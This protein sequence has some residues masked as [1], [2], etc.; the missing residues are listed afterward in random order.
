MNC[1]TPR[2]VI[3]ATLFIGPAQKTAPS[4]MEEETARE[5]NYCSGENIITRKF[6][7]TPKQHIRPYLP[8]LPIANFS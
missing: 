2:L 3:G 6:T 7:S 5:E 8:S 1:V 4:F